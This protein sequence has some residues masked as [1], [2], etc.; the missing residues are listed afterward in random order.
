MGPQ[1]YVTLWRVPNADFGGF[2]KVCTEHDFFILGWFYLLFEELAFT[3]SSFLLLGCR[4]WL[5]TVHSLSVQPKP[6]CA[7]PPHGVIV[8][9]LFL[10]TPSKLAPEVRLS[11]GVLYPSF[12][13][14]LISRTSVG[15]PIP[16]LH[17]LWWSGRWLMSETRTVD[18]CDLC[19]SPFLLEKGT[20]IS[21]RFG[22]LKTPF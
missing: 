18:L 11:L 2:G 3:A 1:K 14:S 8:S 15:G 17:E 10:A 20:S 5:L 7:L 19:T 13:S 12:F 6:D 9:P 21:L 4:V 16:S 22:S